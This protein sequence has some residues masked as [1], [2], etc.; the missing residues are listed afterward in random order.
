VKAA[1]GDGRHFQL[2]KTFAKVDLLIFDDWAPDPLTAEQRHDLQKIMEDRYDR[3][4]TLMTRQ[5][6][7]D[8]LHEIIGDPALADAMLDRVVYNAHRL[9]LEGPS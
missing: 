1:R 2:V 6:P 9:L 4:A 5:L 8:H 7:V 3:K